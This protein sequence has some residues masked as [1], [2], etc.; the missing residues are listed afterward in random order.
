L[1]RVGHRNLS[2]GAKL[3]AARSIDYNM[4]I[5]R[6]DTS[7]LHSAST[8]CADG[9]HA[10]TSEWYAVQTRP[11]HE[12]R[13]AAE[14]KAKAMEGFLPVHCCRNRWKNGVLAEVELP[15]FPCYLFVKFPQTE[16]LRVLQ[17]PGVIGFAVSSSHPTPLQ[18]SEVDALRVL[19][20][21]C[22]A[23]PHPFLK[24]GDRVRIVAG[25][26]VGMEGVLVR[27]AHEL[28][29]VLSLDFIM[30]SVA[31][32]ISEFDVEPLPRIHRSAS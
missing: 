29:V 26:L 13:V 15:L 30:R 22:H 2:D 21:V 31:V 20:V 27:R 10:V 7:T 14:I 11:R 3:S 9:G 32:E 4:I 24:S 6:R 19:S 16:R 1:H 8:F 28:R 12:K 17:I 18:Q 25:P 23:Q 5:A